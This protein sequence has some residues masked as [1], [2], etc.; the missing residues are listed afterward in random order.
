MRRSRVLAVMSST[1]LGLFW[2]AGLPAGAQHQHSQPAAPPPQAAAQAPGEQE[3][4]VG[5]SDDIEFA[6][7]VR[8]GEVTLKPGKYRLRHRVQG[9]DHFVHF[10]TLLITTP[11]AQKLA[12]GL[13]VPAGAAGEVRCRLE[14]LG[15]KAQQTTL[16]L[17]KKAEGG[18]RVTKVVISGENVAH[19]F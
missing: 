3:L 9:A 14:P 2:L 1:L 7:E 4:K 15:A 8:V 13:A 12:T 10:E 17:Q 16:Y 5:K 6:N 18:Q 11:S 19:V